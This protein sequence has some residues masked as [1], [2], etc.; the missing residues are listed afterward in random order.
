MQVVS[1]WVPGWVV[2]I[3]IM[4]VAAL[5]AALVYSW[6][7]GRLVRLAADRSPFLHQLLRRA[8]RPVGALVVLAALGAALPAADFPYGWLVAIGHA[9][10][11]AF[12]L[13]LGWTASK[14][15][16]IAAELYLHRFR[17]DAD[18]NLLARKHVTQVDIL[19]RAAQTLL[20]IVTIAA[21]LMTIDAVRN[22]GLSLFAS[23][24]A[25]GLILGLAARPVLS[26]LLAG[27]QIAVTQPIRVEDT[28]TVEGEFGAI[29]TITSTY[30]VIR[31]GD[32]RRLIVPLSYFIE[33][34]FQ[35]WT[36]QGS[37][38]IGAVS[39]HVGYELPV[40]RVRAELE[41]IVRATPLW[42]G[43]V[44]DV[45]VTELAADKVELRCLVSARNAEDSG[46]LRNAVREKMLDFL[47]SQQHQCRPEQ[48]DET[49]VSDEP[50]PAPTTPRQSAA[51]PPG[52]GRT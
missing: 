21:A 8:Q 19:R 50:A 4:A 43:R 26:N 31:C 36:Y 1:A 47:R 48:A 44:A 33:K 29:E 16:D 40:A 28:V 30:V 7:I 25:A 17:I 2:G 13:V 46:K 51:D 49:D 23:A 35:N 38:L 20:V 11:I 34:P 3:I 41:R 6:V 32:L 45:Q 10:L 5:V 14:A 22:Y 52:R 42:D 37:G 18:D 27:I 15:I 24:G 9:L 39:V 12:V